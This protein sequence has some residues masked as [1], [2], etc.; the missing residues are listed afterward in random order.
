MP[1]VRRVYIGSCGKCPAEY[2]S[3]T[4]EDACR[5]A[6][7]CESKKEMFDYQPGQLV[8]V[9]AG[10]TEPPG[11]GWLGAIYYARVRI[12]SVRYEKGSHFPV[13]T[14]EEFPQEGRSKTILYPFEVNGYGIRLSPKLS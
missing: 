5:R 9:C 1:T 13:Y 12:I 14:V 11:G 7:E 8:F 4:K 10:Y 2:I 6:Q 3:D